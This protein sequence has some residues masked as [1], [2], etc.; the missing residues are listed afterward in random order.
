[1]YFL[2]SSGRGVHRDLFLLMESDFLCMLICLCNFFFVGI[3]EK[4]HSE[5]CT[6]L[7]SLSHLPI[8]NDGCPREN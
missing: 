3:Y 2:F 6:K 4:L 1:M 5:M 8:N 7:Y